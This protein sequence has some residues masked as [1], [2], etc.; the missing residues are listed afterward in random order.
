[1]QRA[2]LEWVYRLAQEPRRLWRRYMVDLVGFGYFFT[3]QWWMMRRGERAPAPMVGGTRASSEP[4][5]IDEVA[6]CSAGETLTIA[7]RE[8]FVASVNDAL[9]ITSRVVIDLT[10]TRFVD[11]S[12][13]GALVTLARRARAD[14]GDLRLAAAQPHVA[15]T[16]RILRM[17]HFFSAYPDTASA[18]AAAADSGTGPLPAE[19]PPATPAG[20]Q[21]VRA[22]RRLDALSAPEFQSRCAA[23]LTTCPRLIVDLSETVFLASAGLAALIALNREARNQ[24]GE[25]RLACLMPDALQV[26]RLARLDGVFAV[27]RDVREA[28]G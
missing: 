10:R 16:L 3:R 7:N 21:T 12:G 20:W 26:V 1:M 17:E 8:P 4:V 15:Q 11:S 19:L 23:A 9:A 25:L 28:G 6:V 14:G 18:L 5:L 27:Y 13:Y 24:D 22:P 2:G